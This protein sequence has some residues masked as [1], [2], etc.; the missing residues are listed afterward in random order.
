MLRFFILH[1]IVIT[2]QAQEQRRKF[3]SLSVCAVSLAHRNPCCN[4]ANNYEQLCA[5]SLAEVA[6]DTKKSC[7]WEEWLGVDCICTKSVYAQS[8][9]DACDAKKRCEDPKT[10]EALAFLD[11][12]CNGMG[13][14]LC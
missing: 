13:V 4:A 8:G 1:L 6:T 7:S 5:S 3:A 2:A 9:G 10:D 14:S 11:G 12:I